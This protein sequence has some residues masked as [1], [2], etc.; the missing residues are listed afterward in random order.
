MLPFAGYGRA[1]MYRIVTP[2]SLFRIGS[3]TKPITAM[4]ILRLHEQG[5]L[6][7]DAL[8]FGEKGKINLPKFSAA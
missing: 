1:S 3:V 4:G 7:L 6:D 5:K 2:W 8:V